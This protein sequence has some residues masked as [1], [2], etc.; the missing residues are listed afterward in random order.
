MDKKYL[1][2]L[3]ALSFSVPIL[4]SSKKWGLESKLP[5]TTPLQTKTSETKYTNNYNLDKL[6]Q[7][8]TLPSNY[9]YN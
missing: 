9:N 6:P 8:Y 7:N 5:V 1:V 4:C 3:L 2:I